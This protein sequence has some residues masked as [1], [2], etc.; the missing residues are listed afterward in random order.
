[1]DGRWGSALQ[2][3]FKLSRNR[4]GSILFAYDLLVIPLAVWLAAWA[5]WGTLEFPFGVR[6]TLA[7]GLTMLASA[8]VFLRSGLYRAVVRYM[9]QQAIITIVQGACV[10]AVALA[11]TS[12]LTESRLPRSTPFIYA[13]LVLV[14]VGG[15]RLLVRSLYQGVRRMQ[16]DRVVIYGAGDSGRQLLQTL[17]HSS[18]F[19]PV[20]FLDDNPAL[21]GSVINGVP[22]CRL[23]QLNEL[24]NDY[25]ATHLL[26]AMPSV[27][28]GRRREILTWLQDY[29]IHVQTVPSMV[30][31]V[32]GRARVDELREVDIG[33]LL[34]RDPVPPNQELLRRCV[35][36]KVVLVTGAGGS[37]GSELCRQILMAAPRELL[38]LDASEYALYAT[39]RELEKSKGDAVKLTPLLGS[40]RDRARLL[41][42]CKD[43][44]VQTVYHAAAY[45]H[46][47]IVEVNVVEGVANNVFGT[48]AA[49]EAAREAGVETFVLIS[50]DKAVRPTNVMGASKR[51]AELVLQSIAAED[52]GT[53]TF[54]MVRFGNV[55]GSSGSVVPLFREQICA[56][57]PV[58]VTHKDVVRYF[59][60][61]PEASQLVI[62]A[63]AMAQGGDVFVL[64][65]GE[66]VRIYDLAKTMIQLMGLEVKSEANPNGDI[67]I[68]FS[69]LRAGEKM[70]EELLIGDNVSG[71]NHPKIMRAE[72]D[73][74]SSEQLRQYLH[75]L[76]L[77]CASNDCEAIQALLQ[78]TVNDFLPQDGINDALWQRRQIAAKS[79]LGG[80]SSELH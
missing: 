70:Y 2:R 30:D 55:L 36:D 16:G 6:E 12:F 33:D 66:P 50:T 21:H 13:V 58:T 22:V 4:K 45:K 47:P 69:G 56:G 9:G 62:Q 54:A 3:V 29:P 8:V 39:C 31:L 65:M 67:E 43:F 17:Y 57:G 11:V 78:Q 23:D 34:G 37:I 5:R 71:T 28:R 10:S 1:M 24:I 27:P 51:L 77:A 80:V 20:A 63:G 53:T 35:E 64:D 59:M 15:S 79:P 42:I 41:Q 46:V 18:P 60:T 38:L 48:L 68:V 25:Q 40:V 73:R 75:G 74:L 52:P 49:A 61:I 26:L 76:Q 44:R 7:V 32:S 19:A 14:F 72:E